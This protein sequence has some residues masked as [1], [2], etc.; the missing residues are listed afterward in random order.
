MAAFLVVVVAG[1]VVV[2]V[3]LHLK[4]IGTRSRGAARATGRAT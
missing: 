4:L 2:V 1:G 3:S